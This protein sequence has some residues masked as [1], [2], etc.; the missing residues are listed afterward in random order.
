MPQGNSTPRERRLSK[1]KFKSAPEYGGLAPACQTFFANSSAMSMP[2][3]SY[4]DSLIIYTNQANLCASDS[5][6]H[7]ITV[8]VRAGKHGCTD[9]SHHAPGGASSDPA[10]RGK[11][12]SRGLRANGAPS[13]DPRA[14]SRERDLRPEG[15]LATKYYGGKEVGRAFQSDWPRES[16]W[17]ARPT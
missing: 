3:R 7:D 17:K 14:T 10:S 6:G 15:L 1:R 11:G 16:S 9:S 2:M 4:R 13:I 12:E 5:H 8:D